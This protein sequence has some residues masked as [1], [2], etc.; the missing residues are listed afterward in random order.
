MSFLL[1]KW[2]I[3]LFAWSFVLGT[4]ALK[5]SQPLRVAVASNF[6]KPLER[7]I[8]EFEKRSGISVAASSSSSGKL[9]FQIM[10]GAPF[11]I[12]L[13]ANHE[14]PSQLYQ[15][16][17]V[18]QPFAY[19]RGRLV[20]WS[21]DRS[22]PLSLGW[23]QKNYREYRFSIA[24]PKTAPYGQAAK[25]FLKTMNL[26]DVQVLQGE[27]VGQAFHFA[28]SSKKV[29]GLVALSQV[30]GLS[31]KDQSRFWEL[32]Q[33]KYPAIIQSGAIVKGRPQQQEAQQFV[34]FIL[35]SKAQETIASLGYQRGG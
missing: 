34:N 22:L 5:A 4:G 19:A 27:S 28:R 26:H 25:A 12:Y 33:D 30:R 7:L 13:A 16:G 35:S 9:Y 1:S 10:Q 2:T 18:L 11:D 17:K 31:K 23:L 24:N 3:P 6:A 29:L 21:Q 32:P 14:Y 8:E 15:Q 20:M